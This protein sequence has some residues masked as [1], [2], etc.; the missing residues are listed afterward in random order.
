MIGSSR[1]AE[2]QK[3]NKYSGSDNGG[4]NK[5]SGGDN[6]GGAKAGFWEEFESLQQMECKHLYSRKE[7]SKYTSLLQTLIN[8]CF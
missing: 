4:G 1:V 6:F 3:E 2:L 7:V 5:Y 8:S